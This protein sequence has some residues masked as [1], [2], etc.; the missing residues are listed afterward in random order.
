VTATGVCA[1]CRTTSPLRESHIYPKFAISWLKNTG[2]G[3]IRQPHEPNRRHQDGVKETLLCDTCEQLFST[4]EKWFAEQVFTEYLDRNGTSFAYKAELYYFLLSLLWRVLQKDVTRPPP[5]FSF[6]NEAVAAEAAWRGYLLDPVGKAP[7]AEIHLF[8]GGLSDD[9][10]PQPVVNFNVFMARAMDGTIGANSK[11]AFVY[12]KFGPF[13]V[14]SPLVPSTMSDM[15]NTLVDPAGGTLTIPQEIRDPNIGE[16]LVHR[17]RITAEMYS[18]GLSDGQKKKISEFA[19]KNAAKIAGS[20]LG[21]AIEADKKAPVDPFWGGPP[22]EIEPT[23]KC[24]CGSNR[25]YQSCH[26]A[27]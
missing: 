6:Q 5:G 8:V 4:R 9:G 25:E 1:L 24:P 18:A 3:Y 16:F 15:V 23:D 11:R 12:A 27:R 26:G 10:K 14:L 13:I 19:S 17:A 21:K 2:S 20:E 7:P 22:A